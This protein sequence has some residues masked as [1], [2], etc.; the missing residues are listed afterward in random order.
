MAAGECRPAAAD[1]VGTLLSRLGAGATAGRAPRTDRADR[2]DDGGTAL[3]I[4]VPPCL[5]VPPLTG[6]RTVDSAL[7]LAR[8]VSGDATVTSV[9]FASEAGYFERAGWPA[10][11][12]GPSSPRQ[13]HQPDEFISIAQ[14]DACVAFFHRLVACLR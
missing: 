3:R 9:P 7:A 8:A 5:T 13:A 1:D 4:A 6:V 14:I 2:G 10:V 11:V 12:C